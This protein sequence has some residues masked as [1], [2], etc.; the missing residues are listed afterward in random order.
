M[1]ISQQY[2]VQ[3]NHFSGLTVHI[4]HTENEYVGGAVRVNTDK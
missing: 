3:W 2:P 1:D 4:L